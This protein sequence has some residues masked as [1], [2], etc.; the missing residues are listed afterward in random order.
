MASNGTPTKFVVRSHEH[1]QRKLWTHLLSMPLIIFGL[2]ICDPY[3]EN[4]LLWAFGGICIAFIALETSPYHRKIE[5]CLA[6]SPLG[7]QRTTRIN[8]KVVDHP[9]LPRE[10]VQ[11]CI[12]TEHVGVFSVSTQLVF[13]IESSS[14]L[15]PVFPNAK[16]SFAQCH[17][18]MKQ[19]QRALHET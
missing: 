14:F 1:R 9:L 10:C 2:Y 17:S 16:L 7:I 6:I 5:L 3:I 8:C 12:L 19:I 18:L 15:V 13:R 4:T 11:D